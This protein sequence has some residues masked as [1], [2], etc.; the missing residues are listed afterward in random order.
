LLDLR[1]K[2]LGGEHL[3]LKELQTQCEG[4]V[5]KQEAGM[6]SITTRAHRDSGLGK[7]LNA[8]PGSKEW[9]AANDQIEKLNRQKKKRVPDDR[10]RQRMSAL[11]V[12]AISVGRWN[13]P[14]KEISQACASD[15]LQDAVNDYSVQYS[16]YAEL[17][18]T[19]HSN[20]EL[21]SAL[22]QWPDR[23]E[24]PTPEWPP[25]GGAL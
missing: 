3:S 10:H 15:F 16:R 6:T 9:K 18:I 1:H 24:L 12:D 25:S 4:H 7:L 5:R 2:V 11:Y 19:R 14:S 17:E 23:P 20:P 13:R 8:R 21:F 22:Q